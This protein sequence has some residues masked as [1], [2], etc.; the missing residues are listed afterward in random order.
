LRTLSCQ[1]PR[2]LQEVGE[3]LLVVVESLP[4]AAGNGVGRS[5]QVRAEIARRDP[6][7][8][9]V[10][11][12]RRA[13]PRGTRSHCGR[14]RRAVRRRPLRAVSRARSHVPAPRGRRSAR[15]RGC[16]LAACASRCAT[17]GRRGDHRRRCGVA[18]RRAPPARSRARRRWRAPRGAGAAPR[19]VASPSGRDRGPPD[20]RRRRSGSS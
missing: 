10:A 2:Q 13:G 5:P 9:R 19:A 14:R 18:R 20:R 4:Q 3:P 16:L 17:R 15:A 11:P 8:P 7:R 1:P 12:S 6:T